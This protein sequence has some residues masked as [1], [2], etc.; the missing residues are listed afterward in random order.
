L[1]QPASGHVFLSV[2]SA[3]LLIAESISP[4][5][6]QSSWEKE[7]K[8][9]QAAGRQEA[10]IVLAIPPS[11]E[12]RKALEV[13]FKQR[14]GIDV[15]LT[16]ATSAKVVKRIADEYQA[17]VRS[18]DVIISTWDNLEHTLLPKGLVE[19]LASYWILPEVRDPQNWWGG[20]I[21]T[22]NAKR[23]AYA[24]MAYMLDNI[25][26]NATMVKPEEVLQY[27]DLLNPKWKGK[28]GM[29]DRAKAARRRGSGLFCG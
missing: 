18:F 17:G 4:A 2:L 23:F 9:V 11:A 29:W 14:F 21:W 6:A 12:L 16:L 24:P 7:W 1:R 5:W 19:P 25:W 13:A 20:H 15:E 8:Q 28:I 26:Y 10:K 22:D 27:D 3:V